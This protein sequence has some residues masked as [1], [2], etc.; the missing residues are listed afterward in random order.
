MKRGCFF[1][2]II[3]LTITI[4]VAFYLYKTYSHEI[5]NFGKEKIV[6]VMLN[7]INDKIDSVSQSSYKD[8]IKTLLIRQSETIN[9]ENFEQAMEKF[10]NIVKQVDYFVKDK[11]IDSVEFNALKNMAIAK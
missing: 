3:F 7:E 6:E 4:G 8:S 1:G 9:F 11:S 10:G 5:T 2:G